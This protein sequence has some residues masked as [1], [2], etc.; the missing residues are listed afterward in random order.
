[1]ITRE[2]YRFQSLYKYSSRYVFF[3]SMSE[4][5]V[6]FINLCTLHVYLN[7]FFFFKFSSDQSYFINVPPWVLNIKMNGSLSQ[8]KCFE[9]KSLKLQ[10]Q[11]YDTKIPHFIFSRPSC[12]FTLN[13]CI[14][15]R[16]LIAEIVTVEIKWLSWFNA[17]FAFAA[18]WGERKC[19]QNVRRYEI[20]MFHRSKYKIFDHVSYLLRSFI[21]HFPMYRRSRSIL[22]LHTNSNPYSFVS[23][24]NCHCRVNRTVCVQMQIVGS[25]IALCRS[26]LLYIHPNLRRI[27]MFFALYLY[28]SWS[29]CVS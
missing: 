18:R 4:C 20:Q 8:F 28:F 2:V 14:W 12:E 9:R 17:P 1:M 25:P 22:Y 6:C 13:A 11:S 15:I 27:N 7:L 21:S 24:L 19:G 23:P 29:E 26:N 10:K 5:L 16:I 3:T